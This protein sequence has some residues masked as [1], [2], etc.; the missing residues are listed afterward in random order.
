M[1]V[2]ELRKNEKVFIYNKITQVEGDNKGMLKVLKSMLQN[3]SKTEIKMI[4]FNDEEITSKSEIANILNNF[5]VN[6]VKDINLSIP[7][8][9]TI[10]NLNVTSSNSKF[11]F[12]YTNVE[13]VQT[14]LS[15]FNSFKKRSK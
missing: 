3:D 7:K 9:S 15:K 12:K 8:I 14:I 5:F 1:Y 2:R 13:Q 11:K 10:V 4:E 6:S